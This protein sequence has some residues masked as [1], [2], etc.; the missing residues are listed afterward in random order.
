MSKYSQDKNH[1]YY[2]NSNIPINK[3]NIRVTKT[4]E[5]KEQELLFKGYEF[6]HNNLSENTNFDEEYFQ[7]LHQKTFEELYNFAGKYRTI[8]I[9]KGF[10]TFCQ[11]RFLKQ[12][13]K[14]IFRELKN[15]NFLKDYT[16]KPK[17]LFAK[18]IAYYMCELIA[19]HPFPELNGRTTRLF[20]DMITTFNGYEYI[21]Y[22]NTLEL[23]NDDE[24][25]FI[26]ASID[27]LSGD[28]NQMFQIILF[29][30]KKA[31]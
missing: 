22:Q 31:K 27:C 19:L 16:D 24:N 1:I 28:G 20:F 4:L 21:D 6:F 3:L 17:E 15:D 12:T 7:F 11:V 2:K 14:S 5:E 30:L 13:S 25:E 9:S 23:N 18:K 10:S 29:G 8:N 26:K